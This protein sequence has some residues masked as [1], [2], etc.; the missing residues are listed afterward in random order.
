MN[1]AWSF[2]QL[3]QS[4]VANNRREPCGDLRLSSK[5]VYMFVSGQHGFLPRILRVSRITQKAEGT[6]IKGR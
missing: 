1:L 4:A 3:H 6:T 2:A 5:L